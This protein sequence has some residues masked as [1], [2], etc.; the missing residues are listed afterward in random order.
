M[1][2]V[3]HGG[4]SEV[5]NISKS[6][7]LLPM[8]GEIIIESLKDGNNNIIKD[9]D[10]NIVYIEAMFTAKQRAKFKIQDQPY[11]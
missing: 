10:G 2:G 5:P 6:T 4:L 1:D 7:W 9:S 8:E 11:F 3:C